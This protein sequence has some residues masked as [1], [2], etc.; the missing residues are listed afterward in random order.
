MDSEQ[1]SDWSQMQAAQDAIVD[2]IA[3]LMKSGKPASDPAVMDEAEDARRHIEEWFYPCSHEMHA[4]LS[5]LYD[6]DPRFRD[7]YESRGEGLSSYVI[8]AVRAN[9]E[10]R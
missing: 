7:Y 9:G 2:R 1:K 8:E 6:T 4:N 10:R 3:A 5:K